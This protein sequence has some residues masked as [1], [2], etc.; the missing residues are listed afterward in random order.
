MAEVKQKIEFFTRINIL[1]KIYRSNLQSL[2][3]QLEE[4]E[5]GFNKVVYSEND[6]I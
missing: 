2:I 5:V 1:E 3:D 6:K 4:Y